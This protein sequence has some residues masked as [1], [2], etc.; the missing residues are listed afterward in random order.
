V[1]KLVTIYLDAHS[2]MDGKWVKATHAD[3]HGFVEEHLQEDLAGGWRI[4]SLCG[5]G[6]AEGMCSRGWL[7]VVLEKC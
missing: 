3:K 4:V 5:I 2:Y 7:A 1:Q 6:G